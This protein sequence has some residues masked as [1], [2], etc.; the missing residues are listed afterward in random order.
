MAD[1]KKKLIDL[2]DYVDHLVRLGEKP[3][4]NIKSYKQ[5]AYHE[6][7]LRNRIGIEHNLSTDEGQIWL[8]IE[9][10][11]RIDPPSVPDKIEEWVAVS[12]DPFFPPKVKKIITATISTKDAETYL[13]EDVLLR[14]D[15]QA[16][17][18][19]PGDGEWCDVIFRLNKKPETKVAIED[20]INCPW[21][22]W[23]ETEKPRRESIRIYESFFNLQQT[24]QTEGAGKP[25]EVVWGMGIAL[26]KTK[27][28]GINRPIVEQLVEIEIDSK[29]GSISIRPRSTNPIAALDPYFALQISG[30]QTVFNF[31][32]DFFDNFPED[33]DLSPFLPKTYEA[34][35]RQAATHLDRNGHYYPDQVKD[36]TDRNIPSVAE[37]LTVTDTW[38]IYARRR[39]DSF[40]K[41]DLERFKKAIEA[42]EDLPGLSKRLVRQPSDQSSYEGG[43]ISIGTSTV[44]GDS[45]GHSL[46]GSTGDQLLAT[47]PEEFFFPK[48]YNEDQISII[49]QLEKSDGLVV[50]GPPGTGKTH[51]IA[52]VIC[53]Y[54][55]TGRRVLV[56]SKG[57]AA[58]TVLREHIPEDIRNLTISL[59]TSEKEG[60]K[61]LETAVGILSNTATQ[62]KPAELERKII[63]HQQRVLDIKRRLESIDQEL[64]QWAVK[65]LK[66]IK[67]SGNAEK[68]L[69][70][71][72]A[73]LVSENRDHHS[74]LPDRPKSGEKFKP[75]FID[76]DIAR[77]RAARK[78]IGRDIVYVDKTLPC[79][80]DLPNST[81]I[82]S[83][84][85]DLATAAKI[86]KD[87]AEQQLPLL[88]ISKPNVLERAQ[89]LLDA[90]EGIIRFYRIIVDAPWVS[91]VFNTWR[92]KG[93]EVPESQ[94]FNNLIPPME[95][96]GKK[97]LAIIAY[98]VEV[99]QGVHALP[100]L[101]QAVDRAANGERAF[102]LV[103]IGKSR[104]KQIFRQI[105]VEGSPPESVDAWRKVQD[106]L[107][108][109]KDVISFASRWNS[110]ATEFDL[111]T[112]EP[113]EDSIG[114]WISDT[115]QKVLQARD[116]FIDHVRVVQQELKALFPHGLEASHVI[117]SVEGAQ[118]AAEI[119]K[120]NLSKNRLSQS[121]SRFDELFKR[122]SRCSGNITAE[123][124]A[125]LRDHVGKPEYSANDISNQWQELC[126]E[127]RRLND[128]QTDFEIV[129][130]IAEMVKVSGAPNWARA[131]LTEAV[132]GAE[133]SWTPG[134]WKESWSWVQQD[135]YLRQ[136]DGRDRIKKLAEQ[137]GTCEKDL[138]KIF[139]KVVKLRTY[140]GLKKN[141]TPRVE[142]AL[143]MFTAAIRRIGGG[144]GIRAHRYRRD[145]RNAMEQ[146][147]A[148][149]PCWIMPS[150]RA[151]ESLPS[152]IGSFDL[153]IVDEASQSDITALPAL[154]RGR[155][156]L[157]VGDDKQ[158]SPTGAF[159]E[160]RKLL[161]LRHNYLQNQPF[162]PLML[163][164]GS[165]YELA[166]A[167][168]PGQRIMLKEHFRC[169]EPIIRFS[170]QFYPEKIIPLRIPKRSE[171]LDP[172]LIDVHVTYGH[173]DRRQINHAEAE[174][175]VKEIETIVNNPGYTNRTIGVVSLIGAQQAYYIQTLLLASIGEDKFLKHQIVCG[176]SATFQGKERD[177]MFVSMLECP[178][179][180]SAKTALL[181][182]QRFNVALSRARDRMYLYRSVTEDM[183]K[184]ND[185]KA[186][187]IRHFN[188]P[189]ADSVRNF[190][191]LID[192]CESGFERKVFRCLV[193][194]GYRVKPQVKVGPYSIDLVVE[195]NEDRRLAIELDGDQYHTPDRWADD[196]ARQSILERVGW[197]FWR[198]WGSSFIMDS[199]GCLQDLVETL[200][201]NGIEPVGYESES[202]AIYT[203][204]RVLDRKDELDENDKDVDT[205]ESKDR[206]TV[207]E[208]LD[209]PLDR[210]VDPSKSE[211]IAA[212]E[213]VSPK[214]E[215]IREEGIGIGDLMVEVGDRVLISYNDEPNLQH[216]IKISATQHDPDMKIIKKNMP[217]AQALLE[218]EV[219]EEVEI[220][221]GGGTR[222]ITILNI[223][224][225][226]KRENS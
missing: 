120:L 132:T 108:Y 80:N 117:D 113:Q 5:L 30:T 221:A 147:Y 141:I 133:D 223:E 92:K 98:A 9:R 26:W 164:G 37:Y 171:R 159:I 45:G 219:N 36:L 58:L 77:V 122:L 207:Y 202:Q 136:I 95:A 86:E 157:I 39:S 106:Y 169:V 140:L 215:E 62:Q 32:S 50:Q 53:H 163:P 186:K 10:L 84:H 194:L 4:F 65:H 75:N 12:R 212:Q 203:E 49:R 52:N 87:A 46:S 116:T 214:I 79:L 114:L 155:K 20:Y 151:S 96:L 22:V 18:K 55:A 24:I 182:E 28:E 109:Q 184:P 185:L 112:I 160:E 224:K 7:D 125:F 129:R 150:W 27:G 216:T 118:R 2:I 123:F 88:S 210:K 21:K 94:M 33:Q 197:R 119:I 162:G 13:E 173:K 142:S 153:V 15:I 137:R 17:I 124:Q 209:L 168:F 74:W 213:T 167:V 211:F 174:A 111:P 72:L 146:S 195:G 156:V 204:H 57:E 44:P 43:L 67:A 11:Q 104:E 48:P 78:K 188:N 198:C 102:S 165:L 14:E 6:V 105:K 34:I 91:N 60:L 181:F 180:K 193:D 99:P 42:T 138:A 217:L 90:V 131:L 101:C 51:T 41:A 126:I 205:R 110:I 154:L 152:T 56:T 148:A 103:R 196:Y 166:N 8:K 40:Y 1:T 135:T 130:S 3:V 187:I 93:F 76:S 225:S 73:K 222:I 161:Q 107:N 201:N 206:M 175:I 115:L 177:I 183:L 158:V 54:L 172:P 66:P 179:T 144:T 192:L 71:D 145:A 139:E 85:Q 29:D 127:L 220:P 38:V 69:P 59:L 134:N 176:N 31:A 100:H 83:I 121:R 191:E 81:T 170:M 19:P 23:S 16:A 89:K 82:T 149:V 47:Q 178:K 189:M 97:R 35:L 200:N 64:R 63:D 218:A 25:L 143:V 68:I 61:Q 128:L 70:M 190:D 226:E 208:Q 199:E